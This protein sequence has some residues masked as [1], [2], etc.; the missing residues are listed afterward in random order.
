M[1]KRRNFLKY[2][3]RSAAGLVG[4]GIAAAV[5]GFLCIVPLPGFTALAR[6]ELVTPTPT[7]QRLICPGALVDVLSLN[8][9]AT[10]FGAVG[11]PEYVTS[12][13]DTAITQTP[14]AAPDDI[15]GDELAQPQQLFAPAPTTDVT[16][17][18]AGVQSQQATTET[19]AGLATT[20][21]T[22]AST[23]AWLVGGSTETGRTTLLFLTNPTEVSANV[24]INV[25]GE[26]GWVVGPGSSGIVVEP[27][28][29]RIVSLAAL[30]PN[31]SNP[32]V[33]VTSTGGQVVPTLQ[34]SVVRTLLPDGVE[35][36]A[37]GASPNVNLV[38][39]GVRLSGMATHQA[40]EGGM[41]TSDQEPAVRI[42]VPGTQESMV[43]VTAYGVSGEPVTVKATVAAERVLELPFG[44]LPDGI[45][46][47]VIM[48]TEPVVVA[49][50]TINYAD[51]DPF[52]VSTASPSPVGTS[53]PRASGRPTPTA[54]ATPAAAGASPSRAQTAALD[55]LGGDGFGSLE[56]VAPGQTL[57]SGATATW[58]P[59][60]GGD[61][62]WNVATLPILGDTLVNVSSGPHPTLTLFNANEND[63]T[64]KFSQDDT[65]L[66]DV[67][68]PA[69]GVR[70]VP[71][72]AGTRYVLSS[73]MPVY[74]TVSYAAQGLGAS[75]S[76]TP[77][78]PLGS[79]I[80]V[81]PR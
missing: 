41:V 45:Y 80:R 71:L 63:I 18:I 67:T 68:I 69:N 46:T 50:R 37:Q 21:C 66:P 10:A 22:Q 4:A 27:G 52:V 19:L 73:E 59:V 75:M 8:G 11:I 53:T 78:S 1:T 12:A 39:P 9:D 13:Q 15:V 81:Y 76:L 5:V 30:A 58:A 65:A 23:D 17:Q 26:R 6:S 31:V 7:D 72:A 16:P 44:S 57:G 25:L 34:Q 70:A 51:I 24:T 33:H 38:I 3:L 79:G 20:A 2:G 47:L 61:F 56:P 64:L 74:A 28:T 36:I 14:V 60:L 62:T 35:L 77:A 40:S 49:A 42:G 54:S 29:Q 55:D 43:T 32:V 48:A